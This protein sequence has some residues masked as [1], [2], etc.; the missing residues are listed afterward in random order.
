MAAI[1]LKDYWDLADKS[2][3]KYTYSCTNRLIGG[4]PYTSYMTI[5]APRWILGHWCWSLDFEK[6]DVEAYWGAKK[7]EED[8][9]WCNGEQSLVF[10]VEDWK[11]CA[12]LNREWLFATAFVM[13]PYDEAVSAV[14]PP[15]NGIRF[16]TTWPT[17]PWAHMLGPYVLSASEM[18]SESNLRIDAFARGQY[19][20]SGGGD[21]TDPALWGKRITGSS[22]LSGWMLDMKYLGNYVVG[23][24]EGNTVRIRFKESAG[25]GLDPD[26]YHVEDWYVQDGVG[27]VRITNSTF[28]VTC[29]ETLGGDI[30]YH[31]DDDHV[32]NPHIDCT[33]TGIA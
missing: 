16:Y 28:G 26:L 8:S 10:Y 5:R 2:G 7:S 22:E 30:N 18:D 23:A 25:A 31:D 3:S 29:G 24:Y 13:F 27:L 17:C 12:Y 14:D 1:D 32:A 15:A 11:S 20:L 6:D 9:F 21:A 19:W 33:L 4:G